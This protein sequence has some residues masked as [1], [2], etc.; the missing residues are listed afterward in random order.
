MQL[1]GLREM[2]NGLSKIQVSTILICLAIFSVLL[3]NYAAIDRETNEFEVTAESVE[4]ND[5]GIGVVSD[6]ELDYGKTPPGSTVRKKIE[7]GSERN[8]MF[9]INSEGNVSHYL[10]YPEIEY[11]EG[12]DEVEVIYNSE[13][14]GYYDGNLSL[15]VYTS[16]YS[17]GERWLKLRSRA[18]F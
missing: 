12:D 3:F 14:V 2:V 1:K 15:D 5:T 10:D 13:D 8:L 18:G 16:N 6:P 17:L 7:I 9:K 4:A 11:L